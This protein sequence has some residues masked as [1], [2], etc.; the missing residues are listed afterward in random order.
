VYVQAFPDGQSKRLVSKGGGVE[1]RWRADGRELF[2]V[3]A[4]RRL[5]V[6]TT[7]IGGAFDAGTPATLFEMNV[8]DLDFR[9]GRR[10]DVTPDG[11]RFVVQELIARG[12]PSALT[13]IV[14][15]S[16]LLPRER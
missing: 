7:T 5:M 16:A 1:P 9:A 15:W 12:S 3:S 13:V 10:Y 11:Q 8:R 4:D 6:V 14:N 2:Y